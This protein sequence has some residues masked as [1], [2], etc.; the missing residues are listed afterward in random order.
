MYFILIFGW[1]KNATSVRQ[2]LRSIDGI[3]IQN[4]KKC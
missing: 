3:Q 1:L 2:T 4:V